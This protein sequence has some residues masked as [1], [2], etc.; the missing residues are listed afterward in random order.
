M[1]TKQ[2]MKGHHIDKKVNLTQQV[3]NGQTQDVFLHFAASNVSVHNTVSHSLY[4]KL[5][6]L[7]ILMWIFTCICSPGSRS[8]F[9]FI[10][11]RCA[12]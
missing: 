1:V 3:L 8:Y 7:H 11:L 12:S 6:F 4:I 5:A 10:Y 2:A 9:Y